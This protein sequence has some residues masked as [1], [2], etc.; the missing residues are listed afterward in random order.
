MR[1]GIFK[2]KITKVFDMGVQETRHFQLDFGPGTEFDFEPGQ[3]VNTLAPSAEDP[4]KIIKRPYSIASAPYEKGHLDLCWKRVGGGFMTNYLWKLKEGDTLQIQ[5]PLGRFTLKQPLPK[6]IAFVAT[7]TGI[8]PFRAMIYDLLH[9][10]TDRDL[11]LLFGN[12]YDTD[13]LY[14]EEWKALEK[15]H[16]NFHYAPTV[17]RTPGW[18]GEEIYVQKLLPKYLKTPQDTHL[19]ICGLTNMINEVQQTTVEMGFAKEQVFFEKYD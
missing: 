4:Q 14:H 13:I 19:Y 15:K 17:S 1:A 11:W 10:R 8:A 5:G 16:S 3:F 12:R 6:R 2:T 18:G 9:K 7:G